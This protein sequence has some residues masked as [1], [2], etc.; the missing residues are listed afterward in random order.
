M[1]HG[2]GKDKRKEVTDEDEV[3]IEKSSAMNPLLRKLRQQSHQP[4][5]KKH[6]KIKGIDGIMGG[7]NQ[8]LVEPAIEGHKIQQEHACMYQIPKCGHWQVSPPLYSFPM[9]A[10][11]SATMVLT[12]LVEL[13]VNKLFI[14]NRV[15]LILLV[16]L[17]Q[18][19]MD[20]MPVPFELCAVRLGVLSTADVASIIGAGVDPFQWNYYF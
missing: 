11:T 13:V 1:S 14:T 19:T 17:G 18:T 7:S 2:W 15:I 12:V 5:I 6:A 10:T 9:N 8:E 16:V 4:A 20:C 3:E